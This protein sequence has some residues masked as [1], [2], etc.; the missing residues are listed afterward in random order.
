MAASRLSFRVRR[1]GV[2]L[3]AVAALFAASCASTTT[4]T[5]G[6]TSSAVTNKS[7]T[8]ATTAPTEVA[9][10]AA[11]TAPAAAVTTTPKAANGFSAAVLPVIQSNCASCHTGTGPGTGELRLDTADQVAAAAKGISAAVTNRVMPP[12]PASHKGLSFKANRSLSDADLNAIVAWAN[13]G[14][15]LDVPPTTPI[16]PAK[17]VVTPLKRDAVMRGL[18][19]KGSTAKADDYHCQVYDPKITKSS[20]LQGMDLEPDQTRVVHHGLLFHAKAASRPQAEKLDAGEAGNGWTCF[21]FPSLGR[22]G[23]QGGDM[24]QLMSWGPGQAPE[25]LP[26]DTGVAMEPGDFFVMQVHY[27]YDTTTEALPADESSL[28]VDFAT[29]TA[30]AA[31]GGKLAPVTL[32]LYLGPAEIPCSTGQTGPL[33]DRPGALQ[34]LVGQFGPFAGFIANGLLLQCGGKVE[35]FAAMTNGVASSRCD[36]PAQP[37]EIV[38]VW[39]HEHEIGASFRM[40]LNPGT[41]NER[42]L[43]DIPQW[44][45]D[46]QLNYYPTDKVVLKASDTIRV[47]CSWDRSRAK[48]GAEARYI[49]WSE[50]TNDE[51]CFSQIV[52]RP[53]T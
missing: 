41:P 35:D 22:G 18:P 19:Y 49:T 15:A 36:L 44:S 8:A 5:S 52:T 46:W 43:L 31:A 21:G 9:S 33:C 37:G 25:V 53:P 7:T 45:F 17:Q 13:G 3:A 40:T 34:Q 29:E 2:V 42:V 4:S 10:T 6:A 12:W 50:G 24:T 32:S 14:A 30:I 38:S 47:E 28:V 1:S 27:H 20:F 26:A 39:G 23:P 48:S 11:T 51:M 16:V